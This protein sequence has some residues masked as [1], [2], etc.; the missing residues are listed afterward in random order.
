[1][2]SH[3]GSLQNIRSSATK[4]LRT[5]LDFIKRHRNI[6]LLIL[7]IVLIILA[8]YLVDQLI[9]DAYKEYFNCTHLMGDALC[10]GEPFPVGPFR[11]PIVP[12]G[13]ITVNIPWT[14][15]KIATIL[16]NG[17]DINFGPFRIPNLLPPLKIINGP[18]EDIRLFIVRTIIVFF[19]L[20]SLVLA[21]FA[22]KIKGFIA[23]LRTPEG[24]KTVLT[25]LN[26]WLLIFAI[27]CSL[28]YF[29]Y[30]VNGFGRME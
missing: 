4:K 28:F 2:T 5:L 22:S 27:F 7:S 13:G 19:A 16:K 8:V 3:T 29:R 14:E 9:D 18:L 1:M 12:K 10:E 30:V 20:A 15:I 23:L 26:L 25:N 11:I 21:F 6:I 24:R 17:W